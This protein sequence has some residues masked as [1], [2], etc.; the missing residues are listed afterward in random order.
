M[1][2][3]RIPGAAGPSR[4]IIA[5]RVQCARFGPSPSPSPRPSLARPLS[6]SHVALPRLAVTRLG[7]APT[8]GARHASTL[9]IGDR[10]APL[11]KRHLSG[12]QWPW[13]V[14]ANPPAGVDEIE[15]VIYA[16]HFTSLG[17]IFWAY[18]IVFVG[19]ITTYLLIPSANTAIEKGIKPADED[20][21]VA[22]PS[23]SLRRSH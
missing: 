13:T 5:S 15:R 8:F 9:R 22:V 23:M 3:S 4:R 11:P 20:R 16:R 7:L 10:R 17:K 2:L 19:G 18:V 1:F 14:V 12:E 21:Y 6:I